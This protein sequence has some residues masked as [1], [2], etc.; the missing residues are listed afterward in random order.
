[1]PASPSPYFLAEKSRSFECAS[2]RSDGFF[3]QRF[4]RLLE[5]IDLN[6]IHNWSDK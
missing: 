6:H 5:G 3:E 4:H 1:V 2:T